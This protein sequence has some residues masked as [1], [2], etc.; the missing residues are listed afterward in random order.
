MY[1]SRKKFLDKE[2]SFWTKKEVADK[3]I[4]FAAFERILL[5]VCCS[6]V[7]SWLLLLS[8]P[9]CCPF[10]FLLSCSCLLVCGPGASAVVVGPWCRLL[11]LVALPLVPACGL[12][13]WWSGRQWSCLWRLPPS[14]F[15]FP[16]WTPCIV[17]EDELYILPVWYELVGSSQI[18]GQLLVT[19]FH[20][21]VC[22][23]PTSMPIYESKRDII[24]TIPALALKPAPTLAGI[25]DD[26]ET[27]L[28]ADIMKVQIVNIM[29][30]SAKSFILHF[31]KADQVEAFMARGLT[32]RGHLLEFAPAKNTTTVIRDRVPYGLPEA[33]IRTSLARYDDV[34]AFRPVT[35]KGYG[36]SKFK[37]EMTLKQDI[38]SRIM[39][40]ENAVNVFYRNQ[41]RSCFVC[42]GTG[43]EAK[44]CPR[45]AANKRA[46]PA[47][48]THSKAPR[49]VQHEILRQ[50]RS[51]LL[52]WRRRVTLLQTTLLILYMDL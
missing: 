11:L 15:G 16:A 41:P 51:P 2:R 52:S 44:N 49:T 18:R 26:L 48:P 25:L 36:L 23:T 24:G 20:F 3:K 45:Q 40:Q 46:A 5:S 19:F 30:H 28:G 35:D 34:K 6:A 39:I 7:R 10:L 47:D 21:F 32:F 42:S 1:Y 37:L 33:G 17:P 9:V 31:A 8:I 14:C 38:A 13:C 12:V 29:Q 43:H 22:V 4:L 27:Q 50:T